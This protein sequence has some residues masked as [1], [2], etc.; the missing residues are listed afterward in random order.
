MMQLKNTSDIVN[1][2]GGS[3]SEGVVAPVDREQSFPFAN[4]NAGTIRMRSNSH[5]QAMLDDSGNNAAEH[6]NSQY[7]NGNEDEASQQQHQKN[8]SD[9]NSGGQRSAGDVL[10]DI[11]TMLENLTEELDS[12]LHVNP[13]QAGGGNNAGFSKA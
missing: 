9:N 11:G 10:N 13:N 3:N 6:H 1:N 12:M 8:M 4:D 2:T 5:V 7:E